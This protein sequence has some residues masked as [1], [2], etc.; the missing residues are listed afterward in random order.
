MH[1]QPARR[2]VSRQVELRHFKARKCRSSPSREKMLES[3]LYAPL[4]L[5]R[6]A[7]TRESGERR[8]AGLE[9]GAPG[10][11]DGA[12]GG[13]RRTIDPI[14]VGRRGELRRIVNRRARCNG[15]RGADRTVLVGV[16]GQLGRK[17]PGKFRAGRAGEYGACRT[18]GMKMP[19]R[20]RDLQHQGRQRETATDPSKDESH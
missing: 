1:R 14:E 11:K 7:A 16:A 19:E 5:S 2:A 6:D 18:I 8:R 3:A 13:N 9:R 4:A 20:Q 17:R 10:I 12:D 15:D